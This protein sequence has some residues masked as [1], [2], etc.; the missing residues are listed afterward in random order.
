MTPLRTRP[1]IV[2][3]DADTIGNVPG[4]EEIGR[5]GHLT[6]YGR[7]APEDCLTRMMPA[8]IV[9]T[10]KVTISR[11]VMDGCPLL[12]LICIA[13][14]GM[15]NV[16]LD[17]ALSKGIMVKN[18]AGYSTESVVQHTF[19]LL[20][21]LM[22]RL[23]YYSGWVR[24]GSYSSS[25]LFTHHGPSF[26]ELS[27]MTMGIIGM[28]TIGRRVAR[29]ASTFGC[30]VIYHSTTGKNLDNPYPHAD[31]DRLMSSSDI[32]TIH[33]PLNEATKN[34]LNMDQLKR[35]KKHA[36]LINTARGGIVNETDLARAL[37]R[38]LIGGAGLDVMEKEP[39]DED[40]PLLHVRYRERLIITPH[41]AWASLESRRRLV[42]GIVRNIT[43]Y[44][45][46][47]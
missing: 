44:L 47:I 35:M 13:A 39:P 18:V 22:N 15:N 46:S 24:S 41:I 29:V 30:T 20:L 34:L 5:L 8:E 40:N 1:E 36:I 27:G 21:H 31:L 25:G 12:R 19:A 42:E 33:C 37:D 14:T 7:T 2:F 38:G 3:L 32:I 10:N 23:D 45:E 43:L 6:S 26:A 4:M 9:I 16:D 28:G 11:Q 17:A